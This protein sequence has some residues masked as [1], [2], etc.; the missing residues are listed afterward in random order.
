MRSEWQ[1]FLLNEDRMA[2]FSTMADSRN[3]VTLLK[4]GK[5][6]AWFS[7]M[8]DEKAIKVFIESVK[9]CEEAE[10]KNQANGG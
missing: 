8:L 10:C 1:D 4:W 3:S 5:P 7:A 6:V 2:G 9:T